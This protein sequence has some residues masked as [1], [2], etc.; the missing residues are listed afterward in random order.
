MPRL[1][2]AALGL[3][4]TGL[5]GLGLLFLLAADGRGHR[6]LVAVVLLAVGGGLAGIGVR[7]FRASESASPEQLRADLLGLARARDGEI[8]LEEVTAALGRRAVGAAAVLAAMEA[9]GLCQR[10]SGPSGERYLF[11]AFVPRL[12]VRRCEFCQ[13]ELPLDPAP[14][15]CPRCGGST[16][17]A[18]EPRPLDE[19]NPYRMD[20]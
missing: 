5:A 19:H 10:R 13:A 11:A 9:E 4:G 18:L 6:Y 12:V 20:G 16:K 8:A 17:T 15:Q 14:S 7:L 2:G 1:V 3:V